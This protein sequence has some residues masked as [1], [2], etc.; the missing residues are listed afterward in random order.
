MAPGFN[1]PLVI[2]KVLTVGVAKCRI[3]HEDLTDEDTSQALTFNTLA[4]GTGDSPVPAT[5]RIIYAWI[6]IIEPFAG[7]SAS[8][9]T[10]ILGDA[11]SSN[12]LITAVSIFTGASGLK[13]KT[14]SYTL[15]TFEA[16]YAPIVTIVSTDDDLDNLTAGI[17]EVC[18][19]YE[20]IS[21]SSV[22]A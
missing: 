5:A 2:D 14:G 8:A 13:V 7:G 21:T 6:N 10:A 12:E 9:V 18:I 19:Q 16:A 4:V 20:A 17:I 22:T 3:T 1:H 11:G 15:G